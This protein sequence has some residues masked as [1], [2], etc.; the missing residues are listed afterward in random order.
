MDTR[1]TIFI[2]IGRAGHAR[3]LLF[4]DFLSLLSGKY[5]IVFLLSDNDPEFR[6]KF[7]NY[8]IEELRKKQITP[9]KKRLETVFKSIHRALI[10]NPSSEVFA[11]L[12][13]GTSINGVLLDNGELVNYKRLRYFLAKHVFGKLLAGN[14]V[15]SFFKYLDG[16]IFTCAA[17]NELID[18]YAPALVFITS[19]GSDDQVAL[20]R[21]C[22]QRGVLCAGM[23]GSWDNASKWGFREKV[24]LL[25]V[26][27]DYM[28]YEV[29]RF[30]GYVEEETAVIC[31]PQFDH[32]VHPRIQAKEEFFKK[33]R[34]D[35]AKKTIFFG[36]EGPICTEDPYVVSFLQKKIKDGALS[37]Y[38]VLVRP[39]FNYKERDTAR[40]APLVDNDTVFMDMFYRVSAF[41]DGVSISMETA[42]NLIAEIR[43]CD[44]AITSASTLVLDIIANGKQPILYS[45]D[46]NKTKPFKESVRRLYGSLWFREIFK[47]GLDNVA[48]NEDELIEKIK[49][50]TAN[51]DKDLDKRGAL[52]E[53]LC[54]RIDGKSGRRL[55]E[56][57]D[58]DIQN[59]E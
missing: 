27:S 1:Q 41:K 13:R 3:N 48:N 39:H 55:F 56:I 31:I 45:F 10:F 17:Y 14:S 36:S 20:L 43:H 30:Q 8:D 9:F 28:K 58:A 49:E 42:H 2:P 11:G 5:R 6:E 53:R 25:A 51:P 59:K 29:T 33:F 22:K 35:P 52:I 34:L 32:Y 24:G 23:A 47:F 4:H 21:N 54:Y 44:V 38:Q 15:R 57:V 12:G 18:T 26:W 46:E 37:G 7:G 40:Y 50:I 16:K 19:I